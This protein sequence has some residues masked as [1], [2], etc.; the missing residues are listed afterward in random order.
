MEKRSQLILHYIPEKTSQTSVQTTLSTK[1]PLQSRRNLLLLNWNNTCP[2]KP[3]RKNFKFQ[4]HFI[5]LL[6]TTRTTTLQI[7]HYGQ[8]Q[9]IKTHSKPPLQSI[10]NTL[11]INT[12][13]TFPSNCHYRSK[14]S[15]KPTLGTTH[16]H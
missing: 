5:Q 15:H 2:L 9:Q 11:N 14:E 12:S 8:P 16:S 6:Q 4:K 7:K 13:N 10:R 3:N 1:C